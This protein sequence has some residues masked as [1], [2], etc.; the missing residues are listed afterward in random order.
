VTQM[1][2]F[3]FHRFLY[4][5]SLA[6][7]APSTRPSMPP[8]PP[9]TRWSRSPSHRSVFTHCIRQAA[10]SNQAIISSVSNLSLFFVYYFHRPLVSRSYTWAT[11]ATPPPRSPAASA[12]TS[13]SGAAA[14]PTRLRCSAA[15]HSSSARSAMWSPPLRKMRMRK[16]ATI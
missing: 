3:C 16:K 11:C 5:I 2:T 10:S 9:R 1:L 7:A 15:T 14:V 6:T 12:A 4:S 13:S 8:R